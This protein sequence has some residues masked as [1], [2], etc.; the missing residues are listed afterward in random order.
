MHA[1]ATTP[2]R[3][4][5]HLHTHTY[6]EVEARHADGARVLCE[7]GKKGEGALNLHAGGTAG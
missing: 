6:Q 3:C 2:H 4:L 7:V 5:S 1:H